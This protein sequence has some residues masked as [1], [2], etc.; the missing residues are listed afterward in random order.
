MAVLLTSKSD[1]GNKTLKELVRRQEDTKKAKEIKCL[2]DGVAK[3]SE[4]SNSNGKNLCQ[5]P[6]LLL[7]LLDVLKKHAFHLLDFFLLL[8]IYC[9]LLP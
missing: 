1:S 2:R 4:L 3:I 9:S 7:F 5:H 6:M 8:T